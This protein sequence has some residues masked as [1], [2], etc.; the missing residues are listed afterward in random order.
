M[1]RVEFNLGF[2]ID[3]EINLMFRQ[4][5][6]ELIQNKEKQQHL[7]ENGKLSVV[8]KFSLETYA[9]KLKA[10]YMQY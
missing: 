8:N 9:E 10:L 3:P 2:R 5:I 1:I 7:K 4:V 6:T